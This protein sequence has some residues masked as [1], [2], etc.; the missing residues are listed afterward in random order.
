MLLHKGPGKK[1]HLNITKNRANV[2]EEWITHAEP[3]MPPLEMM[4]QI[5]AARPRAQ[6]KFFL[7]MTELHYRFLHGLDHLFI[8]RTTLAR[9]IR[10]RDDDMA[11]SLQPSLTPGTADLQSPV[12]GQGR[13]FPH[14]HAKGHGIVGPTMQWMRDALK[15]TSGGLDSAVLFLRDALLKTAASVQYEAVNEPGRQLGVLGMPLEP[16]TAKQRR[17]S[18]MDGGEDEETA[19]CV[20]MCLWRRLLCNHISRESTIR[21]SRKIDCR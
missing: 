3:I 14:G 11:T 10:P 20:R 15:N 9:P 8:G 18:R 5:A 19:P 17:Q 12:E 21:P 1:S 2:L 7:L 6:A 4:H 13:G 16:F